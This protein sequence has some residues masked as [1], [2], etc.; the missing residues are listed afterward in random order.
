[1]DQNGGHLDTL[2]IS[3]AFLACPRYPECRNTKE[4]E[5]DEQGRIRVK[6]PEDGGVPCPA[7]GAPTVI[8]HGKFGRFLACSRYPDCQQTMP[9]GTGVK[10]PRPD[11]DGEIVE[12]QSRRKRTF[13]GCNRYPKCDYATWNRP[14]PDTRCPVCGHPFLSEKIGRGG[15]RQRVCESCRY[16]EAMAS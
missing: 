12:K 2:P 15:N 5:R 3:A 16:T 6:E 9:I 11:C 14:L 13:S 7:C 1:M 8:K 10:C 4:F